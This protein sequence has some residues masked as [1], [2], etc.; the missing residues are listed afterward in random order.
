[1]G[2]GYPVSPGFGEIQTG[3]FFTATPGYINPADKILKTFQF[4]ISLPKIIDPIVNSVSV[5]VIPCNHVF[6]LVLNVNST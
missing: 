5:I 1:M 4:Q 2:F 3:I 6:N